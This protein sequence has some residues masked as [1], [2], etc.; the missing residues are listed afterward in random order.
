M[1]LKNGERK[2]FM[3]WVIENREETLTDVFVHP[4]ELYLQIEETDT[5]N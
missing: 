1:Y 5:I 4:S 2:L 3:Q